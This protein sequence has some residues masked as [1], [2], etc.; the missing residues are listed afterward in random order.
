MLVSKGSAQD[1][2]LFKRATRDEPGQV[3]LY[4]ARCT[5][6]KGNVKQPT[7][8]HVFVTLENI[9]F[10]PESPSNATS[11]K[12]PMKEVVAMERRPHSG[13]KTI[14]TVTRYLMIH[15]ADREATY[16]EFMKAWNRKRSAVRLFGATLAVGMACNYYFISCGRND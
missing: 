12:I 11:E 14:T 7:P 4:I 9:Y 13:I 16:D 1:Q 3:L 2:E 15:F 10:L 6:S 8:G 5:L